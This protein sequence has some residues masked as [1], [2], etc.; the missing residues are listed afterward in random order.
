ML[1]DSCQGPKVTRGKKTISVQI[2]A[3]QRR[4]NQDHYPHPCVKGP[5][6]PGS[7]RRGDPF[8]APDRRGVSQHLP[9]DVANEAV[10]EEQGPVH[11]SCHQKFSKETHPVSPRPISITQTAEKGLKMEGNSLLKMPLSTV[12]SC[13]PGLQHRAESGMSQGTAL[14][15]FFIASGNR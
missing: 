11:R 7:V 13:A 3:R 5:A 15:L 10:G 12:Q 4:V 2:A 8:P 1:P 14:L 6:T 9:Q